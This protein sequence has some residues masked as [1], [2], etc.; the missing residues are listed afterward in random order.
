MPELL[1]ATVDRPPW[2][3]ALG[4]PCVIQ[5]RVCRQKKRQ[6]GEA[7]A[8]AVSQALPFLEYDLHRQ[9]QYKLQIQG[10]NALFGLRVTVDVGETLLLAVAE[11]TGLCLPLLP[12][13]RPLSIR[14]NIDVL[15]DEDRYL[16]QLQRQ[17]EA[18][19][20]ASAAA[21][22]PPPSPHANGGGMQPAGAMLP[23]DRATQ[24]GH[25]RRVRSPPGTPSGD[26]ASG[27][28]GPADGRFG[29]RASRESRSSS[30]EDEADGRYT[31]GWRGYGADGLGSKP[32]FVVDVDDEMDEDMMA[33]LLDPPL[34][35]DPTLLAS[36]AELA[37]A[38]APLEMRGIAPERATLL[39]LVRRVRLDVANVAPNQLNQQFSR[40]IHELDAALA[41]K[42]RRL[43]PS[44]VYKATTKVA[45]PEEHEVELQLTAHA[46]RYAPPAEADMPAKVAHSGEAAPVAEPEERDAGAK[47]TEAP[48]QERPAEAADPVSLA[49]PPV[50]VSVEK[51]AACEVA[52]ESGAQPLAAVEVPPV[53]VGAAA[54]AAAAATTS[55]TRS[56]SSNVSG[57]VVGHG[58][59]ASGGGRQ[60]GDEVVL[61]PLSFVP[62]C[63]TV[64]VLGPLSLH[65]IKE[66][67]SL[68]EEGGVGNFCHAFVAEAQELARAHI[69][70]R[71]GNAALH[72]AA[73]LNLTVHEP[74]KDHAYALIHCHA[75]A[76]LVRSLA[77]YRTWPSG[78]Q[79]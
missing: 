69:G 67:W 48:P 62:G 1:L 32:A 13:A 73:E 77:E 54:A 56:S 39:S 14:R 52:P 58:A 44:L 70:A 29:E 55:S 9:L 2:L 20:L 57:G 17:I 33:V 71:G 65:L 75:D 36:E 72:F 60:S 31:G 78:A 79:S 5:A 28:R 10:K 61:V 51:E 24:A 16:V 38:I 76:A 12:P 34:P 41:I 66:T 15:D 42:V 45:Q 46:L 37:D 43:G 18:A 35:G 68:R 59:S 50:R 23:Q 74:K 7:H 6:Q 19:S 26:K 25:E 21:H 40:A 47:P 27:G 64:G 4:E 3:P 8:A 22:A 53:P 49:P 63:A 11:A 30:S